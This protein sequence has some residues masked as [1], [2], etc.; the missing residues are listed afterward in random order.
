MPKRL[1]CRAVSGDDKPRKARMK[2]NT[3][4][5]VEKSGEIMFHIVYPLPFFFLVHGKHALRHKKPAEYVDA[6]EHDG[7]ETK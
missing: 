1:P 4:R 5:D 2:K 7:E 6:G 3:G